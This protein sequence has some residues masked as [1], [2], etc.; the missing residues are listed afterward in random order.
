MSSKT[1]NPADI[2]EFAEIDLYKYLGLKKDTF[3]P[4]KAKTQFK[5]FILKYHPDRNRGDPKAADKFR[6]IEASYR[7]LSDSASRAHYDKIYGNMQIEDDEDY[8]EMKDVDRSIF[9]M[10]VAPSKAE[11]ACLEAKMRQ[12][13]LDLDPTYYDEGMS[14]KMSDKDANTQMANMMRDRNACLIDDALNEKFKSDMNILDNIDDKD[15]K[16]KKFNEMFETGRKKTVKS[17]A[18]VPHTVGHNTVRN[19]AL[20]TVHQTETMFSNVDDI[21]EAFSLQNHELD[22]DEED[23]DETNF[24]AYEERYLAQ[25]QD[26]GEMSRLAMSSTLK[27]G[28]ADFTFDDNR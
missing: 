1:F 5:K 15:E 11:Q 22:D 4:A 3:T 18:V 17:T 23:Y 6:L 7:I 10:K 25:L 2:Q 12:K 14:G 24:A 19:C 26:D 27:N 28:R 9:T 21:D 8:D 20:A 13:N 16:Q